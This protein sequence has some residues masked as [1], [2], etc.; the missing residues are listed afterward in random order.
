MANY[1]LKIAGRLDEKMTEKDLQTKLS[2]LEHTKSTQIKLQIDGKDYVKQIDTFSKKNGEL[3]KTE[4]LLIETTTQFGK[5]LNNVVSRGSNGKFAKALVTDIKS[6]YN[7]MKTLTTTTEKFIDKTGATVTKITETDNAGRS[8]I[9]TIT[10]TT[11]A[12]GQLKT[13]I[14]TTDEELNPLGKDIIKYEKE[15]QVVNKTTHTY[16]DELGRL[17]TKVTEL[18]NKG[19]SRIKET[20]ET[21]GAFGE[22]TKETTKYIQN[23]DGELIKLGTTFKEVTLNEV[24]LNKQQKELY[25]QTGKSNGKIKEQQG[26]LNNFVETFG[27]VI[28]FQIITKIITG[29]TTACREAVGIVKE[30]DKQLTEM[31]KVSDLSGEALDEYTK[32]L[33]ELGRSVART[34]KHLLCE[35]V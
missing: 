33:G 8:I 35:N 24:E 31:K 20:V 11:N 22:T 18:D 29:F 15:V 12:L 5:V 3:V 25:E 28:K 7:H 17:I 27:K 13:V 10:Q 1:E 14:H 34:R 26:A 9:K 19:I 32:K 2:R 23:A 4:K 21:T 16:V 30:F 6:A